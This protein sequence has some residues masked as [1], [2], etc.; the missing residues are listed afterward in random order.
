[1]SNETK[2]TDA[3]LEQIKNVQKVY[4]DVVLKSG[5]L[6]IQRETLEKRLMDIDMAMNQLKTDLNTAAETEKKLADELVKKY[7][8]GE[9]NP[10]TGIFI[11]K[12]KPP[13]QS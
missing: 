4:N 10:Q 5:Q 6:F 13:T 1:M 2:F 8:D 9:L 11:P 3:E 12:P 7:G